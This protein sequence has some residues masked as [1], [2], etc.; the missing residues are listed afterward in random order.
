MILAHHLVWTAYGWWLPK[1]PRGSMSRAIASD[2]IGELGELHYGRKRVQPA[3]RDIRAFYARAAQVLKF[4]L[5]TLNSAELALVAR[6]FADVIVR[7]RHTCYACAI[8]PDH[9]HLV[10]RR[11]KQL[12]EQM[13][14]S[15]QMESTT[16]VRDV[17]TR[18]PGHPVWG[19]PG[20]KVFLDSREDIE[21]TV[22]YV[23]QNPAKARL[24]GQTWAFVTPYDRWPPRAKSW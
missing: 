23:E 22:R 6:A 16:R 1:D 14:E 19:G 18:E 24:P 11:H 8:M 12:A 13:I 7:E 21:R 3:S 2:V 15:F 4:E 5:L 20:W 10:I 9:V 17:G